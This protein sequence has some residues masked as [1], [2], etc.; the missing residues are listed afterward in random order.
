MRRPRTRELPQLASFL[1]LFLLLAVAS[2]NY[3]GFF[4]TAAQLWEMRVTSNSST[5]SPRPSPRKS[6]RILVR[7]SAR[8]LC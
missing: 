4:S 6:G 5:Q 2:L 8:S 1:I 7:R 3:R